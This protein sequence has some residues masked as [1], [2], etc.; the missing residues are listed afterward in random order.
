L[1]VTIAFLTL[2]DAAY[3]QNCSKVLSD[4]ALIAPE[5][6]IAHGIHSLTLNMIRHYFVP[7][8][9]M[10]NGIP[11]VNLNRSESNHVHE[12][13]IY[14][15]LTKSIDNYGPFFSLDVILSNMDDENFGIKNSNTLDRI[16]HA[17]HMNHMWEQAAQLYK[18]IVANPP[19][20]ASTCS[21]LINTFS[22]KI[23]LSVLTIAK[24]IRIPDEMAAKANGNAST[25][26]PNRGRRIKENYLTTRPTLPP[27]YGGHYIGSYLGRWEPL[28][29]TA[30]VMRGGNRRSI[31]AKKPTDDLYDTSIVNEDT[32][33]TWK[34]FMME[35]YPGYTRDSVGRGLA[36]YMYCH[37]NP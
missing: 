4:L 32:W 11:T 12:N 13:A 3:S 24:L 8:A 34:S 19:D 17:I 21:C 26:R 14:V 2:A 36:Y 9:T 35:P 23:A 30:E 15:N 31:A 16:A 22:E 25:M 28:E 18:E 33:Q 6:S 37:F 27:F 29:L 5:Q 10:N 7:E 1:L 20:D